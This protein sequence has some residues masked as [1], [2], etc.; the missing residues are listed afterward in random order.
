MRLPEFP[1]VNVI[2]AFPDFRLAAAQ[3]PSR[4]KM[5]IVEAKHLRSQ[6]GRNMDAVGNMSDGNRIFQFARKESGPHGAGD[7]TV[8]RGNCIRAPRELQA[9][10]G[11]AET[12]VAFGILASQRHEIFLGKP[13]GLAER[14]EVLFDQI[15]IETIMAGGARR[16]GW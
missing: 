8:Q 3:M 11:H 10:H 7:F 16:W 14:S 9:K 13:E 2:N 6:P 1:V 5:T 15:G 12:F 4:A